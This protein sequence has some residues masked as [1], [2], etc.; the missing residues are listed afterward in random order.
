[1]PHYSK[2]NRRAAK[3]KKQAIGGSDFHPGA[4]RSYALLHRPKGTEKEKNRACMVYFHGG[5]AVAGTP[6]MMKMIQNR[7]AV[8]A[9]VNIINVKY[10]LAPEAKYP[11]GIW[12]CYAAFKDVVTNAEQ[13]GCDP[14]RVGL[15]GDSGGGYLAA[16][17]GMM[18]AERE[19]SKLARF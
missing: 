15:F 11:K 1:M 10:R 3:V 19:E 13:W 6:E 16:G 9:D 14:N 5:G 17:V 12:D 2:W 7:A 4:K 18:L 8:K